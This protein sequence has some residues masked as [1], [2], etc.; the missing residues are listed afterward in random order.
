[1]HNKTN[2]DAQRCVM[3]I[4]ILL[5][6]LVNLSCKGDIGDECIT[7]AQCQA[8][9]I[10]DLISAGGYCTVTPCE[11]DTCPQDSVCVTFENDDSFCMATCGGSDDCR[12]G[13]RCDTELGP[14]PFC[15]QSGSN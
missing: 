10:C 5:L 15:R 11:P 1:M 6:G 4:C 2:L 9:Q 14:E 8:G 7:S 3:M 13:Y 12:D